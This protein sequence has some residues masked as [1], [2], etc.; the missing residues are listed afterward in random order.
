M[1]LQVNDD[2][3]A[4]THRTLP[5]ER[6]RLV[7]PKPA[8]H[9]QHHPRRRNMAKRSQFITIAHACA[10]GLIL[11]Y[12]ILN[13]SDTNSSRD[14][15]SVCQFGGQQFS[16]PTSYAVVAL[17][18]LSA[19]ANLFF[20]FFL[21]CS[22]HALYSLL[23]LPSC[24]AFIV[25]AIEQGV[26]LTSSFYLAHSCI[27]VITLGATAA[28][29]HA[30]CIILAIH[31][32]YMDKAAHPLSCPPKDAWCTLLYT[33]FGHPAPSHAPCYMHC[34]AWEQKVSVGTE[35][36]AFTHFA[37]FSLA[38]LPAP[39]Y[40]ILTDLDGN[41]TDFAELVN[42]R[43]AMIAPTHFQVLRDGSTG[44]IFVRLHP[45]TADHPTLMGISDP[46]RFTERQEYAGADFSHVLDSQFVMP[47]SPSDVHD[48]ILRIMPRALETFGPLVCVFNLET[49]KRRLHDLVESG[50]DP[51]PELFPRTRIVLAFS[52]SFSSD[53]RATSR[54]EVGVEIILHEA[55]ALLNAAP[56]SLHLAS[57]RKPSATT[58]NST[59]NST[60]T[61]AAPSA[62][63][64][65]A[66]SA[67]T[68]P[69]KGHTGSAADLEQQLGQAHNKIKL[70]KRRNREQ[71]QQAQEQ[72]E[73]LEAMLMQTTQAATSLK[74]KAA[75][76]IAALRQQLEAQ[77]SEAVPVP[78]EPTPRKE[79]RPPVTP[80]PKSG[81]FTTAPASAATAADAAPAAP[82]AG[83]GQGSS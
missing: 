24:A 72:I 33:E 14:N 49:F 21:L 67:A 65:T 18:A 41:R 19:A 46:A 56:H 68:T 17:S 74:E 32:A 35:K 57:R 38:G 80:R 31:S 29:I 40:P 61:S 83:P 82:A 45:D 22:G 28:A 10:F 20:F 81:S 26:L 30:V 42:R 43:R 1:S 2:I 58:A 36:A 37:Q 13:F 64:S 7:P 25:I 73:R 34:R 6:S 70:L 69:T 71:Q 63:S 60:L 66:V 39:D 4:A 48:T 44:N 9:Q 23:F 16:S 75:A 27:A 11:L 59:I 5:S 78:G 52:D 54:G 76:R 55:R 77:Q 3:E 79:V 51:R 8:E 15:A 53:L 50:I 47:A 62:V 12:F